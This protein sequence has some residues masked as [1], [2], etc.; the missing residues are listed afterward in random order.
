MGRRNFLKKYG[1]GSAREYFLVVDG[2]R[3]DSKAIIGAAHGY[4]FPAQGPLRHGKF[5]GG[6]ATV[7]RKLHELGFDT[8]RIKGVVSA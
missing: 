6:E 1:F 8:V 7:E 2:E 4:E 5:S 3:F